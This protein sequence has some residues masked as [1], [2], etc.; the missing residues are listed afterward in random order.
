MTAR[1]VAQRPTAGP[2]VHNVAAL[3]GSDLAVALPGLTVGLLLTVVPDSILYVWIDT[4]S[5][6]ARPVALPGDA[7]ARHHALPAE[8]RKV[9]QELPGKHS[10]ATDRKGSL[11]VST[12]FSL[13]RLIP[14]GGC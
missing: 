2:K 3:D 1:T 13:T 7:M 10:F 14:T 4:R 9:A 5:V 11:I 6:T 8:M 12:Q